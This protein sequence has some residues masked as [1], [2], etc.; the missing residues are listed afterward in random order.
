MTW[1]RLLI[2]TCRLGSMPARSSISISSSSARGSI[3]T[4]VAD[5]D[6]HIRVQYA[7]GDQLKDELLVSDLDGVAGVMPAL[8][9][10]DEV[11]CLREEIDDFALAFVT[12]LRA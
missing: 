6:S 11:E 4:P 5:N 8:V 9:P 3:T 7:A 12:P 10:R 1:A 2:D